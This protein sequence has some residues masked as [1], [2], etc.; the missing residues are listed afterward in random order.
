MQPLSKRGYIIVERGGGGVRP[1]IVYC[2][3]S[4]AVA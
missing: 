4:Y 1:L 3:N 2:D